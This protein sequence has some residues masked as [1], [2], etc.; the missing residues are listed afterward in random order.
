MALPQ[1]VTDRT[2]ADVAALNAK[3][4]Y[5]ATDLN[6]VGQAVLIVAQALAKLDIIVNVAPKTNWSIGEIPTVAE[7]K[8]YSMDISNLRNIINLFPLP[9]DDPLPYAPATMNGLTYDKANDIEKILIDLSNVAD[10]IMQS[11]IYCGTVYSG[12]I[13]A[14]F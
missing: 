1:M 5:N 9:L 11:F 7:M 13:W 4:T 14:Q 10:K 12:Q 8:R 2:A 6:R 3:G